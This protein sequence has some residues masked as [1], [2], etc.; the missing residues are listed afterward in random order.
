MKITDTVSI[1][2]E[3]ARVFEVF[4]DL[5]G[6]AANIDAIAKVEILAGPSR[7]NVGTKWRE[8]RKLFGKEATEEMW[9]TAYDQDASYVV[10]AESRGAHYRSE[11][12]FAAEG[13]GTRVTM[14]FEGIPIS[15]V[16]RL[17]APIGLLFLGATKKALHQ[18]LE[19]LKSVCEAA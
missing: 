16:A 11:Y 1:H 12:L 4:C 7:L 9:V 19:Q 5:E 18:D 13:M 17:A 15:L 8:T 2:A 3:P 14:T 6:A 10:E